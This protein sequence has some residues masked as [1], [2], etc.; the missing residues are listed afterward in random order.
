VE[1]GDLQKI[2]PMEIAKIA[3]RNQYNSEMPDNIANMLNN[4]I[5]ELETMKKE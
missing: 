3:Y 2:N 4:V 1:Y 5:R